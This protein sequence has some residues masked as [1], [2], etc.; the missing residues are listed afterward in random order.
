[1][2]TDT[3]AT[4][5]AADTARQPI[6]RLQA[7]VAVPHLTR[8][9]YTHEVLFHSL[10][11]RP[12]EPLSSLPPPSRL[13]AVPTSAIQQQRELLKLRSRPLQPIMVGVHFHHLPL[14]LFQQTLTTG[15]RSSGQTN[16]TPSQSRWWSRGKGEL[17]TIHIKSQSGNI[18]SLA[19]CHSL[20]RDRRPS[21]NRLLTRGA[22]V[23]K[24]LAAASAV[25]CIR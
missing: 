25:L 13:G 19:E 18:S 12:P 1:M 22:L 23:M 3:E 5:I 10:V 17:I 4:G 21:M 16:K 15:T 11:P 14:Q 24:S 9:L 6:Y 2:E 8:P 20:E 7:G